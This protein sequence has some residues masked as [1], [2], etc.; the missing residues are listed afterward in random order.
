MATDA[1]TVI[2]DDHRVLEQLFERLKAGNGDR[3]ALVAEVK[4]RLTAHSEAEESQV[5]P[6]IKDADPDE[7]DEVDHAYDEHEEADRLLLQVQAAEP[8][9]SEFDRALTAF[10]DAVKH[11]V[12]EEES[13]VL[14]ALAQA[15][16]RRTLERLGARFEEVRLAMLAK[17]GIGTADA[18]K[19]ELYEQ[20]RQADVPGRSA[21]SKDELAE[22]LREQE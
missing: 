21:M 18:S 17:A 8:G 4:A 12:E 16:D 10:V 22:A 9:S 1:V 15:V 11:H 2:M 6:A 7:A 19:S 20:A 13:E 5:Y 14:P 3:R